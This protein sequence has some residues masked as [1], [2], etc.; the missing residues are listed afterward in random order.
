MPHFISTEEE[1]GFFQTF[2]KG[3]T[4]AIGVVRWAKR[5]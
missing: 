3:A 2:W 1:Q 5:I 4:A